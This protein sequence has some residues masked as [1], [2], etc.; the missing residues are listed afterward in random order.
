MV[1]SYLRPIVEQRNMKR[2]S[3]YT[4]GERQNIKRSNSSLFSIATLV[5]NVDIGSRLGND[6][7]GTNSPKGLSLDDDNGDNNLDGETNGLS[8]KT[9]FIPLQEDNDIDDDMPESGISSSCSSSE[10]EEKGSEDNDAIIKYK[11]D[12]IQD[13]QYTDISDTTRVHR[14]TNIQTNDNR[15]GILFESGSKHFDRHNRLHKERPI[16]ITAVQDY[17]TKAKPINDVDKT[18]YER[19]ILLESLSSNESKCRLVTESKKAPEE[20]WLDDY[21]YLR[22]HLPGYMQ[23]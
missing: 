10:V 6:D 17:L 11:S 5:D 8:T 15:T 21:E 1:Y 7:C 2:S 12:E 13:M 14:E 9:S 4:D 3:E 20:L 18:I 16:R 19:C 22:V 23:R